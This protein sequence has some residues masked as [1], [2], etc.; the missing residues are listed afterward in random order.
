MNKLGVE[1]ATP[2]AP[3]TLAIVRNRGRVTTLALLKLLVLI[4]DEYGLVVLEP[5]DSHGAVR[6]IV[7]ATCRRLGLL[8]CIRRVAYEHHIAVQAHRL[9]VLMM[10]IDRVHAQVH[11]HSEIDHT[12]QR[13]RLGHHFTQIVALV[14]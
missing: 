3:A 7:R 5:R 2:T 11:L 8:Y 4:V 14:F 10:V 6:V 1:L 12:L 9:I 13:L